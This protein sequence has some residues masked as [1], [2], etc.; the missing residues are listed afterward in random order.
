MDQIDDYK[1]KI[2]KMRLDHELEMQRIRHQHEIRMLELGVERENIKKG[3][4]GRCLDFLFGKTDK[5][6]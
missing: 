2:Y 1:L 3:K 5:T 6:K 4:I